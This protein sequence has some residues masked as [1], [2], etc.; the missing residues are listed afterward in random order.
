MAL[1]NLGAPVFSP[2]I[3]ENWHD[4]RIT[5]VTTNT[6][7]AE[8]HPHI[9]IL[10]LGTK[11]RKAIRDLEKGTGRLMTEVD[12]AIAGLPDDKNQ[13]VIVVICKKKRRGRGG[14]SLPFSPLNPLSFL[15]C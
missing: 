2:N 13:H 3:N 1:I 7:A 14:R 12:R 5:M 10:D 15:R 6:A 4:R 9:H 8:A 11:K